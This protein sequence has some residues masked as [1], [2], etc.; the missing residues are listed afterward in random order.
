VFGQL[1]G[2]STDSLPQPLFY[3]A[4]ITAWNYFADCL[5]KTSTVFRDNIH[6]FGKVYFPRII[7]PLSIII[8]NLMKFTIQMLLFFVV[9]FY[10]FFSGGIGFFDEKILLFPIFVA[11]MGM[12]G[13]GL[14]MIVSALTTKYR[15]LIFLLTFGVQLLMYTTTVIYPLSSLSG[16]MY[17]VVA[18]N[19]MTYI[20]EGIRASLLNTGILD[21]STFLFSGG[22]SVIILFLGIFI[23]NSVEKTFV[24][25][26]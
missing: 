13:L 26:I 11:F 23:F 24:D 16:T 18:L 25:T 4:G 14:G 3:L 2:I 17:N 10:Y 22:T 7:M 21:T 20:I 1:A 19:P 8:S 15:D 5:N 12:Q 9:Y 6:I